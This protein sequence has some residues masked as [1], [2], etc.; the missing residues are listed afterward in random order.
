ME[1]I[2]W[3]DS[4][5]HFSDKQFLNI[6]P[7][8]KNGQK[9]GLSLLLDVDS[10]EYSFYPM[11]AKGFIIGLSSTGEVRWELGKYC[12]Q[13]SKQKYFSRGQWSGSKVGGDGGNTIA[14]DISR[15]FYVKPGSSSLVSMKVS[16]TVTTEKA[17][18]YFSSDQRMCYSEEEF[19]P[20]YFNEV[21]SINSINFYILQ[22]SPTF[23][24]PYECLL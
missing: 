1:N 4:L 18:K 16:R 13:F 2:S 3:F 15:G 24:D 9:N 6:T 10:F 20:L 11:S 19:Q 8:A 17:L 12:K 7:G 22:P 5:W 21:L 14:D 23:P